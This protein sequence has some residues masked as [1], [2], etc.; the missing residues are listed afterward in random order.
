MFDDL[1]AAFRE[2]LENFDKELRR[3][4]VSD[5]ADRLLV[6]MRDEIVDEKAEVASLESQLAKA[7]ADAETERANAATCRRRESMARGI[8]DEETASLAARHAEKHESHLVLLEKKAGAI[9]EEIEFRERTVEEMM[10]RFDEARAKRDELSATAGRSEAR[11]SFAEADDLF[12]ELD[13]M[14]GRIDDTGAAGEAAEALGD[15]DRHSELH[16]DLD[17]DPAPRE[18]LDVDAALAELKRRMRES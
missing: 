12:G 15:L 13:R 10:A 3:D 14:A 2:A 7:L 17:A 5:T 9:R 6:G 8:D 1:R 18:A 4:H 16:V 11:S